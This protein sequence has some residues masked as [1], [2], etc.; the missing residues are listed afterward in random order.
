MDLVLQSPRSCAEFENKTG[1]KWARE[2]I[3]DYFTRTEEGWFLGCM[4]KVLSVIAKE[5]PTQGGLSQSFCLEVDYKIGPEKSQE[6][7][8]VKIPKSLK[9]VAMDERE[10]VMY[11]KIFPRLQA[12]KKSL[13]QINYN[14]VITQL[15]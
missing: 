5:N 11:N 12:R 13:L 14:D 1:M 6:S 7:W 15:F 2:I 10:L 3:V 4:T 8:F 9:T